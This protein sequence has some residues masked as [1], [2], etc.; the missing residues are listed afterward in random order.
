MLRKIYAI[1]FGIVAVSVLLRLLAT[2]LSWMGAPFAFFFN[3]VLPDMF[4]HPVPLMVRAFLPFIVNSVIFWAFAALV[5]RRLWLLGKQGSLSPPLA[6]SRVPYVLTYIAVI[7]VALMVLGLV[8]AV[9]LKAGSGVPA[10]MLGIPAAVLLSPVM[11]WVE[12]R[13]LTFK[14]LAPS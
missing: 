3:L 10:A 8:A 5:L 9:A 4:S 1:G 12:I 2:A 7:S 13:S 14:R 11:A 6:F